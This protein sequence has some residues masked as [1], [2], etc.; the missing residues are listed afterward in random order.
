VRVRLRLRLRPRLRLRLRLRLRARR[1]LRVSSCGPG[2]QRRLPLLW[3]EALGLHERRDPLP[4]QEA[5]D[6]LA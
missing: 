6:H 4:L 3:L 1:K 2:L 5:G